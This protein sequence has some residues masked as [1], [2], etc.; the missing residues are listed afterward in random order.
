M[1]EVTFADS[2]VE[3]LNDKSK[4][5]PIQKK[6]EEYDKTDNHLDRVT[7]DNLTWTPSEILDTFNKNNYR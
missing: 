6:W 2:D 7:D 5:G 1:H 4:Y 3:I